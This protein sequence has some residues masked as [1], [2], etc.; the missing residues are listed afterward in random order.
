[1]RQEGTTRGQCN[2]PPYFWAELHEK[3]PDKWVS[4]SVQRDLKKVMPHLPWVVTS[5]EFF[6]NRQVRESYSLTNHIFSFE[7]F[8]VSSRW[9]FVKELGGKKTQTVET[10]II[11]S[12]T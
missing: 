10:K 2:L 3:C 8:H 6:L 7:D 5:C 9:M 12:I 11:L 4:A 1:M